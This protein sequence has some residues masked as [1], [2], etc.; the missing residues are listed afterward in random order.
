M[1]LDIHA[2]DKRA[3]WFVSTNICSIYLRP[4]HHMSYAKRE[5]PFIFYDK[6]DIVEL[7][8]KKVDKIR[9]YF[10]GNSMHVAISLGF[11]ATIIF[12]VW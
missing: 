4:M 11:D 3:F 7:V 5:R 12:R 8:G 10:G 6:D 2:N 9:N 1:F